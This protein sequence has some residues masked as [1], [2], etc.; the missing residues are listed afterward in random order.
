MTSTNDT[1]T[2]GGEPLR[3]PAKR[4]YERA[5]VGPAEAGKSEIFLDEKPLRTPGRARLLA[6]V[7]VAEAIAAEWNNQQQE[8]RPHTMPFTRLTNTA[9]DGVS[10][11]LGAVQDEIVAIAGSDLICYRANEPE[12]LV[13][14]QRASWDPLVAHA[15]LRTGVPLAV[16]QG[17]MPVTQ[18]ARLADGVRRSLPNDP[19]QVGALHQLATLTGSAFIALALEAAHLSFDEAWEAAH[20]DEDWNIEEWGEDAEAAERRSLRRRDA[21]AA[22]FVLLNR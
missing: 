16:T 20:I 6:P 2:G 3:T 1:Q 11:N 4:F 13:A 18:D 10:Q 7:A 22:A 12:G 21:E 17:I 15:G 19:L 9:I 14:R 8:I 5:S